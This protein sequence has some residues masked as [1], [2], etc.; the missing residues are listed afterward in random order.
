MNEASS[1]QG[2]TP[3]RAA[4]SITNRRAS[5]K[6]AATQTP[7]TVQRED[8]NVEV[9]EMAF[10]LSKLRDQPGIRADLVAKIRG[11]IARGDYDTQEKLSAAI[12]DMIDD[13]E[14]FS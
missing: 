4:E 7:P 13:A 8:D 3:G 10:F 14:L 11:E 6:P 12:D 5:V 9:S 1:I 2:T